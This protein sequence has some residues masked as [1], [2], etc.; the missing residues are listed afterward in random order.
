MHNVLV[1]CLNFDM[2]V[3]C[4]CVFMQAVK[5]MKIST[6]CELYVKRFAFVNFAVEKKEENLC[7]QITHTHIHKRR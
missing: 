5:D 6:I 4:V 1:Q 3:Y 7:I 2:G